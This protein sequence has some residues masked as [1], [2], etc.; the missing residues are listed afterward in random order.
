MGN[1]TIAAPATANGVASI[2]IIRISGPA[3]LQIAKKIAP[4]GSFVPRKAELLSLYNSEKV[5]IDKA[6]VLYFSSPGSF[7]GE[8]IIEFQCHGG[9]IVAE[10]IL[11]AVIA[12][13][14]RL[15]EPGEFSKRAFVNGKIDLS[16]AEAIAGLIEAKSKNAAQILAR[17]VHGELKNFIEEL[18]NILI[19][20]LAYSEVMIDS[21]FACRT[22]DSI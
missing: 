7:T 15:A 8:D 17:Q 4:G 12:C 1:D 5:L 19:K 16:E 3:A 14:A 22:G 11:D 2:S 10:E 20:M 18:R 6:I 21:I 13:G 9:I